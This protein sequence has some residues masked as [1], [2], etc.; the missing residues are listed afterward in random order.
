L[1]PERGLEVGWL[2]RV[3]WRKSVDLF[4]RGDIYQYGPSD[5]RRSGL[6]TTVA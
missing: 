4:V 1:C 6:D 5:E 2:D 3:A